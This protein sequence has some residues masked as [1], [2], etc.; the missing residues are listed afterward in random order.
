MSCCDSNESC[1][2]PD[3]DAVSMIAKLALSVVSL[4]EKVDGAN[5]EIAELKN[6]VNAINQGAGAMI[7]QLQDQV[8]GLL[9]EE[10]VAVTGEPEAVQA[11]VQ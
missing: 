2:A 7:K 5:K 10:E 6:L 11:E 9:G 1:A 8:K 4:Q 3:K